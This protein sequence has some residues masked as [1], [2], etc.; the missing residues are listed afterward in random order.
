MHT[1]ATHE[2][3]CFHWCDNLTA[4]DVADDAASGFVGYC[5][6]VPEVCWSIA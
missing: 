6:L 1:G 3:N 4:F 2:Q 5:R